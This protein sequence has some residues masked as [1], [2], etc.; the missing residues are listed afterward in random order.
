MR[1]LLL[2]QAAFAMQ[3]TE[4]HGAAMN[5]KGDIEGMKELF[6]SVSK[7]TID[8]ATRQAVEAM[9]TQ[10]TTVLSAAVQDDMGYQ[11]DDL[12]CKYAEMLALSE[13]RESFYEQ[14]NISAHETSTQGMG[15]THS[16]CRATEQNACDDKIALKASCDV[17]N[18]GDD[19]NEAFTKCRR[20]VDKWTEDSSSVKRWMHCIHDQIAAAKQL[21]T[22]ME[23]YQ[24]K[25][26]LNCDTRRDCNTEQG[27]FELQFCRW[28][29]V[30]D[31]MCYEYDNQYSDALSN[32]NRHQELATA[33]WQV[34]TQQMGAL[35]VLKCYGQS[36]LDNRTDLAHCDGIPCEDCPADPC[37]AHCPT[38]PAPIGCHE[39]M[40]SNQELM[41]RP[42]EQTFLDEEY[43]QWENTC[44]PAVGCI[45]CHD[46]HN[47]EP[48]YFAGRGQCLCPEGTSKDVGVP[49][50]ENQDSVQACTE[51][52]NGESSCRYVSYNADTHECQ[53]S[54]IFGSTSSERP[55]AWSCYSKS[56]KNPSGQEWAVAL[57]S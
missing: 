48:L 32:Y 30:V 15:A 9:M 18:E 39:R 7:S 34:A 43:S 31:E 44:T 25:C 41:P 37:D 53:G 2:V 14:H 24:E 57:S 36:I 38:P 56:W 19:Q 33:A 17:Q 23:Q 51:Q 46:F 26:Q 8:A 50:F 42:C 16:A 27:N 47:N 5:M 45:T 21:R 49:D 52:C 22:T 13:A 1:S 35:T 28:M 11:I 20:G 3:V 55:T 40:G 54:R 12:K 10:I 6:L 4:D 29:T